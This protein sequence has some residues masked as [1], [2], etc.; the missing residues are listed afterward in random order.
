[1]SEPEIA[2]RCSACGVSLRHHAT[3][4][5][6]CGQK[7]DHNPSHHASG[8]TGVAD[9]VRERVEKIL[10]QKL[11]EQEDLTVVELTE[12][13][14]AEVNGAEWGC[15]PFNNS[16]AFAVTSIAFTNNNSGIW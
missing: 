15:F 4:C 10:D 11:H 8:I 5:P 14:L 7:I 2:H 6:Q 16:T 9:N 13:E 3:Y 1:M 12:N